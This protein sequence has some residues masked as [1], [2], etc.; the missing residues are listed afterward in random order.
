LKAN[1]YLRLTGRQWQ[2][3]K[4]IP[5]QNGKRLIVNLKTDSLIEARKRRDQIL[6]EAAP[7]THDQQA[8]DWREELR[9]LYGEE[10][11]RMSE[12]VTTWAEE[13]EPKVGTDEAV[14]LAKIAFGVMTP[15][16][17]YLDAFQRERPCVP[18]TALARRT[19]ILSADPS[20]GPLA[21]P[22]ADRA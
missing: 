19:A 14:K 3:T 21:A 8:L 18:S 15:I 11:A 12:V 13:I 10:E 5:G 17:G 2:L 9:G 6:A 1:A 7:R 16:R 22:R 4:R 20:A